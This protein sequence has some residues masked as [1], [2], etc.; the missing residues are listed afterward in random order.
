MHKGLSGLVFKD[1]HVEAATSPPGSALLYI[2][3]KKQEGLSYGE[4][5][6]RTDLG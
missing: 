6:C 5:P 2:H 3:P 1:L 4:S